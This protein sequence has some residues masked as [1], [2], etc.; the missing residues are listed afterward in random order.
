MAKSFFFF[1]FF[2]LSCL[3]FN[4]PFSSCFEARYESEANGKVFIM[5]ISFHLYAN[6]TSFH[7]QSFALSLDSNSEMGHC[8]KDIFA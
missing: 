7:S 4:R 1:F 3:P 8:N 6:V 5:K 2:F